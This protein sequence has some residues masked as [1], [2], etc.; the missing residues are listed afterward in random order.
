M[1]VYL[2]LSIVFL[3]PI[4]LVVLYK[5]LFSPELIFLLLSVLMG[6]LS[7]FKVTFTQG[8]IEIIS[9]IASLAYFYMPSIIYFGIRAL[10]RY[11][12]SL[13][14]FYFQLVVLSTSYLQ[15][16]L[17]TLFLSDLP[18]R[19]Y[20]IF[21]T[22]GVVG[23][24]LNGSILGLDLYARFGVNSLACIYALYTIIILFSFNQYYNNF[25]FVAYRILGL[26][27]GL[28]LVTFSES[29]EALLFVAIGVVIFIVLSLRTYK[30][31]LRVICVSLIAIVLFLSF[32]GELSASFSN[33]RIYYSYKLLQAGDWAG[34][35]SG[36]DKLYI[37]AISD[38]RQDPIFG[39]GFRGYNLN[40]EGVKSSST[41]NQYLTVLWKMGIV[42]S[43]FYIL[44][45]LFVLMRYHKMA[46]T[47]SKRW[48]YTILICSSVIALV[49]DIF[50][51][52]YWGVIMYAFLGIDQKN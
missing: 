16:I 51:V 8:F 47:V 1:G 30:S 32:F 19:S 12:K 14:V 36:R 42:A 10:T 44:H 21:A 48:V 22:S 38:L 45:I 34:F 11:I 20:G 6:F 24:Y 13:N 27:C 3:L 29:R 18:V 23:S 4:G 37:M 17:V 43:I 33:T 7:V 25:I 5:Y 46:S 2:P 39:T 41:H 52:P 31:V 28:Y 49:W 35:S 26:C 15:I 9:P 40:Y 50:L